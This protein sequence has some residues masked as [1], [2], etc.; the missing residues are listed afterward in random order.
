M[1]GAAQFAVLVMRVVH[2]DHIDCPNVS[3]AFVV[4]PEHV[5]FVYIVDPGD[6]FVI[7]IGPVSPIMAEHFCSE[8]APYGIVFVQSS[9]ASGFLRFCLGTHQ[10]LTMKDWERIAVDVGV[11]AVAA[12]CKADWIRVVCAQLS[13]DETPTEQE[14]F[15]HLVVGLDCKPKP[16]MDGAKK[17]QNPLTQAT[18]KHL[19]PEDQGEFKE[20]DKAMQA[21]DRRQKAEHF[22]P[23]LEKMCSR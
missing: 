3:N 11:G 10:S 8:M 2:L 23:V 18:F 1:L 9:E 6:W 21:P 14:A 12:R 17:C 7:P 16:S 19:D 22:N 5:E 4:D 15:T 13:V 20:F